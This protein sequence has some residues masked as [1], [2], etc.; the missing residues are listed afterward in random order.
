MS[1]W[2]QSVTFDRQLWS[3]RTARNWLQR[4]GFRANFRNKGPHITTNMIRYRQHDPRPGARTFTKDIG[5][6]I[7]LI[8][9]ERRLQ[10][11]IKINFQKVFI[12]CFFNNIIII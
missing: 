9:Q 12:K 4:H 10:K 3:E 8:I 6:G 7:H 11:I 1:T 2:V 5:G